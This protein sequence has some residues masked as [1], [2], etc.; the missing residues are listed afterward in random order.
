MGSCTSKT[1]GSVVDP[2]TQ[3]HTYRI[4]CRA[5][6]SKHDESCKFEN[7]AEAL[8]YAKVNGYATITH[9]IGN[10]TTYYFRKAPCRTLRIAQSERENGWDYESW[11]V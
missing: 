4:H 9:R 1:G 2:P 11:I 10:G 7:A 3:P 8:H 5:I 6:A